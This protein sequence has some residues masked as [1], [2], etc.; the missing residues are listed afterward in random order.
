LVEHDPRR[1]N[2]PELGFE[3]ARAP[4]IRLELPVRFRLAGEE[5]WQHGAICNTSSSG[6]LF[7]SPLELF[8]GADIEL[9]IDFR[10]KTDIPI[11]CLA[12]VVRTEAGATAS[13]RV[14]ARFHQPLASDILARPSLP[15]ELPA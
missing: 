7:E 9:K 2:G 13:A 8:T 3:S 5:A 11:E 4:R 6:I 12:Q 15:P 14:A 10:R 1:P